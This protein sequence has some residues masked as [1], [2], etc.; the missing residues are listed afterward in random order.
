MV[1]HRESHPRG[2]LVEDASKIHELGRERNCADCEDTEQTELDWQ[3]LVCTGYLDGDSH[4]EFLV[5]VLRRLLILFDEEAAA[6][7]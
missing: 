4:C 3:N 1:F 5:F 2:C 6:S 7:L